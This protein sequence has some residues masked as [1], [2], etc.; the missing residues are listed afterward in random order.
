MLAK[1]DKSEK[2]RDEEEEEISESGKRVLAACHSMTDTEKLENHIFGFVTFTPKKKNK[3][4][5]TGYLKMG[6]GSNK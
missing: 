6:D 1:R 3:I 5:V 4:P 2:S